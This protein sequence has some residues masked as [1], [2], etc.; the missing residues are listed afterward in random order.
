[1]KQW[2]QRKRTN[3]VLITIITRCGNLIFQGKTPTDSQ[4]EI[5][6]ERVLQSK[7]LNSV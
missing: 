5:I 2:F 3:A 6:V 1:M 7:S 4:I